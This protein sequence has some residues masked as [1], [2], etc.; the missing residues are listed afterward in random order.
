MSSLQSIRRTKVLSLEPFH[1][2]VICADR[3]SRPTQI[4]LD[5][6]R[7]NPILK[8]SGDGLGLGLGHISVIFGTK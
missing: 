6:H 1:T 2:T 5:W 8:F 3:W 7:L 4:C